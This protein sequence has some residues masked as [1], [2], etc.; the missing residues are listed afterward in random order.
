MMLRIAIAVL[1]CA[2]LIPLEM[3]AQRKDR[4]A[5]PDLRTHPFFFDVFNF[6]EYDDYGL[7]GRLDVFVHVPND[8]ITFIKR[9]EFYVGGY[10]VTVLI[11]DTENNRLL[12]DEMWERKV[13][14]LTFERTNNPAYYD[15]SQRTFT[16][17][18]GT[19]LLEVL[20]EDK[21]SQ[22]EYRLSRSVTV[23]KF[24]ANLP[25]ISDIMLVRNVES[26]GLRKQISPQID[27]NVAALE[28]GFEVFF[29]VYNPWKLGGVLIDYSI[30]RRGREVYAKQE[31]QTVKQGTNSYLANISTA[32]LGIGSYTITVTVRR[33][34]DSSAAG[35]LAKTER[36]FIIEWL[37]SGA[38]IA[39]ADLDEAID[40]LRYYASSSDL[41]FIKAPDDPDE[42]RKRFEEFWERRN[43]TPGSKTNPVM[44]EY[45]NRVAY[46][47]QNFGHF[48]TGWKTDRGMTY[49]IY[50]PPDYIDRHPLDVESRPYEIWEYYDISRRFIFV[51]ETGFGDY[52]LLYPTWD[53]RTRLR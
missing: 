6:A 27:P 41:S 15:L 53:E 8:I 36:Q 10:S 9:S 29:E 39:I 43:P 33:S 25:G 2:L 42:R 4:E 7:N 14:L 5:L 13:E 47:N 17:E 28:S 35:V 19:Y 21:E 3:S 40:Q 22:K 30:R 16:L 52:R 44:V 51:D 24:D 1:L 18:P 23:V 20:Y 26:K 45:Y 34:D 32:G 31:M 50:G 46:A 12:R 48:I 11:R 49:I 37:T 38:P